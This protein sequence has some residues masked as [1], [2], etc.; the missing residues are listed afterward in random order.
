MTHLRALTSGELADFAITHGLGNGVA[1]EIAG[2][3]A[4]AFAPLTNGHRDF[5]DYFTNKEN[6]HHA[7]S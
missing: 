2:R 6:P 3:W 5:T 4:S 1:E 7:K